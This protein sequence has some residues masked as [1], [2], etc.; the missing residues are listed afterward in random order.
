MTIV[1]KKPMRGSIDSQS[2]VDKIRAV[3]PKRQWTATYSTNKEEQESFT[4]RVSGD[5]LVFNNYEY[6]R[7]PASELV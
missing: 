6:R 1:I 7:I 2:I 3:S 5:K 4:Y